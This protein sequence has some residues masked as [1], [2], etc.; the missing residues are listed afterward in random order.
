MVLFD[1][2]EV[3]FSFSDE[4]V[5]VRSMGSFFKVRLFKLRGG[6]R[7]FSWVVVSVFGRGS[8]SVWRVF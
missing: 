1:I 2:S 5:L 4:E 3:F 7:W 8:V 6:I